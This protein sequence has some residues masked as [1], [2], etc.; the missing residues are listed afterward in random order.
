M[1][2]EAIEQKNWTE[3]ESGIQ[4]VSDALKSF[5]AEIDK[6]TALLK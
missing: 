5:S 2:R 3:A 4:R 6:A 1:V